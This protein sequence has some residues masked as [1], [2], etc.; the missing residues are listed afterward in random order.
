MPRKVIVEFSLVGESK[1][2]T[3]FEIVEDI[4]EFV[5]A[6]DFVIPW[7]GELVDVKMSVK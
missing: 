6:D 5:K 1:D 3:N 2:K 4:L 7:I